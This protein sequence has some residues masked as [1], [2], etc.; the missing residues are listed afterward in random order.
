MT[1]WRFLDYISP[2][3][4]NKIQE[5]YDGLPDDAQAEFDV[6]LRLL[7][8][9]REWRLARQEFKM[10][11]GKQK[12]LGEM[13]FSSNNVQYRPIGMFQPGRIFVILIGC[14]KKGTRYTPDDALDTAVKRRRDVDQGK[15]GTV[16]RDT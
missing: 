14:S 16:E 9:Q 8:G 3:G 13:R 11:S 2:A 5:W 1:F 10:L 7:A 4:T 6:T 12:Q 15:A